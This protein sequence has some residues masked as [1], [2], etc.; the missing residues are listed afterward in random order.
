[1]KNCGGGGHITLA[2][3]QVEG[4]TKQEVKEELIEKIDEYF[5]EQAN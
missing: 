4:K 3:A 5:A 2:G 1:M